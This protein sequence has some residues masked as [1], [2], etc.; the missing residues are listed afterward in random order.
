MAESSS[1]G[2]YR[3]NEYISFL[4]KN[5]L[6]VNNLFAIKITPPA[7]LN[8]MM[9]RIGEPVGYEDN[10]KT[11]I[12]NFNRFEGIGNLKKYS[13]K[14]KNLVESTVGI[15]GLLVGNNSNNLRTQGLNNASM[16]GNRAN[17]GTD[18][19]IIQMLCTSAQLP[20]YKG[21]MG[22]AFYNHYKH[23]FITGQDTDAIPLTFYIDRKDL[24]VLNFFTNWYKKIYESVQGQVGW[25]NYKEEYG[26][27]I[28][29]VL[30]NK[31]LT[32]DYH[33]FF[34]AKLI[35]AFP[36]AID[37]INLTC[38]ATELIQLKVNIEFDK[39]VHQTFLDPK[40]QDDLNLTGTELRKLSLLD[41]KNFANQALSV[42]KD[43]ASNLLYDAQS[44]IANVHE[45]KN[46]AKS[47]LD[48]HKNLPKTVK[49]EANDIVGSA[50]KALTF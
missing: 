10:E 35:G 45:V 46:T 49:T 48:M 13:T 40:P 30:L 33:E 22:D 43:I 37:P 16:W 19:Q 28:E 11:T 27:E 25:M 23:K 12:D 24:L 6:A 4:R 1:H 9:K 41:Q 29:I 15:S 21:K 44:A 18:A 3:V 31:S 32:G 34:S 17:T 26:T 47:V 20:F 42:T 7:N 38:G 2:K 39:I 14:A 8:L 50:K 36:S 5:G